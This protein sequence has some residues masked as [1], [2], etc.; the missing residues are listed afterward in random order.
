MSALLTRFKLLPPGIKK[1]NGSWMLLNVKQDTNYTDFLAHQANEIIQTNSVENDPS[2][3]NWDLLF[4]SEVAQYLISR[5]PKLQ[6]VDLSEY[7]ELTLFTHI[8][9]CGMEETRYVCGS[10]PGASHFFK[11]EARNRTISEVLERTLLLELKMPLDKIWGS[12]IAPCSK[13]SEHHAIEE[14]IERWITYLAFSKTDNSYFVK[15]NISEIPANDTVKGILFEW[16]KYEAC[17]D[18]FSIRNS[19]GVPIILIRIQVI[20]QKK[21]WTFYSNGSG[22]TFLSA[23]IKA[24]LESLQYVPGRYPEAWIKKILQNSVHNSRLIDWQ[25]FSLEFELK[26]EH[27]YYLLKETSMCFESYNALLLKSFS[28]L[29]GRIISETFNECPGINLSC[30]YIPDHLNWSDYKGVPIS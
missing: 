21:L 14:C 3:L 13:L 10:N 24:L 9:A 23:I 6:F 25:H 11:Q 16:E 5:H 8:Q 17:V 15:I 27:T 29:G 1:P 26:N 2:I 18:A 30:A 12:A 7:C 19:F 20:I 4:T 22:K 28:H